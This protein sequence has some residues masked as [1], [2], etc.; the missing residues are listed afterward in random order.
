M[1]IIFYSLAA[2][3]SFLIS[4]SPSVCFGAGDPTIELEK[5]FNKWAAK[6][7][8]PSV[9]LRV[10]DMNGVIYS[11][12]KGQSSFDDATPVTPNS[13]FRT[14]SVGKLF[15]AVAILRLKEKGTINLDDTID[16]YLKASLVERLHIYNGENYG[17]TITIR[18][19]L[20]HTS[21]LPNT[22]DNPGFGQWLMENPKKNRMPEELLEYAI[23]IGAL[24]PPG[25]GQRYSSPGYTLLGLIIEAATDKPYH[26]IV[27]EEVL[28]P[29]GLANTFEH[30]HE[31]PGN[32]VPIHSYVSDYDMNQIHPSMEFADGGFVTTT[33]DLTKFGLALNR[34]NPFDN[35]KTL[36]LALK[37]YGSE[38]IG[39]GPF[40]GGTGMSQSFFYHPG[41]WG[42]LLYVDCNKQL[43]IT[44]TVNQGEIDYSVLVD[45]VL[46]FLNR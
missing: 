9:V 2:I 32:I 12:A 33:E 28:N 11:G 37:P 40:V 29:M 38:S 34:G 44:Y 15:T 6:S 27:R 20:G 5:L 4:S 42:V 3:C 7:N 26:R 23:Q 13:Y 35:P 8:V 18:Q 30:S 1:R 22:D 25:K 45:K 36:E 41:H 19:L 31:L 39:L 21:G 17:A 16:K 46:V 14:A 24:F 10:E 43:A